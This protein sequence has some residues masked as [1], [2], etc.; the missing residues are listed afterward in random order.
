M[1]NVTKK[2]FSN[3]EKERICQEVRD[4]VNHKIKKKYALQIIA[5]KYGIEVGRLAS[6][7]YN[8]SDS[9]KKKQDKQNKNEMICQEIINYINKGYSQIKA[10]AIVS[11]QKDKSPQSLYSLYKSYV[12]KHPESAPNVTDEVKEAICSEVKTLVDGGIKVIDAMKKIA[13]KY[14]IDAIEIA[15]WDYKF[16]KFSS[17]FE[18]I[19]FGKALIGNEK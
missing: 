13:I 12:R 4:L 9:I 18:E 16:R 3:E 6:W 11:M 8:L 5:G 15:T 17:K 14:G 7:M 10:I 1:N 2:H 19:I